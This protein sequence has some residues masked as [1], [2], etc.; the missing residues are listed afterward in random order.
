[1]RFMSIFSNNIIT[2]LT[3][4]VVGKVVSKDRSRYVPIGV[5]SGILLTVLDLYMFDLLGID[6]TINGEPAFWSTFI[7][8]STTYALLGYI[9]ARLYEMRKH[10]TEKNTVIQRQLLALRQSQEKTL[11]YEKLA[12]IGRLA[13]GVAHEVRNPLGVIR[14]AAGLIEEES[15]HLSK[16]AKKSCDF[17]QKE[18]VRLDHFIEQLLDFSKPLSPEYVSVD[19]IQI[20]QCLEDLLSLEQ[21][22]KHRVEIKLQVSLPTFDVDPGLITQA[23]YSLLKNAL[24]VAENPVFLVID[25]DTRDGQAQNIVA[26]IKDDGPGVDG[27][28]IQ[29]LYEPF[30]T[31]KAQGTG[32]GLAMAERII[33]GHGGSIEYVQGKGL[34]ED[35]RGACFKVTLPIDSNERFIGDVHEM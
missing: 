33:K 3:R 24:E 13:A 25:T 4:K 20:K 9:A 21:K 26:W 16:N 34:G 5:L 18:I 32:L 14:S 2:T 10:L 8:L 30:F 6:V 27:C 22:E 28:H 11:Q 15:P 19:G 23:F 7:I 17:I 35:G 12:S 1:M 29:R 31:T